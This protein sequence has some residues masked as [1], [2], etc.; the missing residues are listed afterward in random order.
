MKIIGML[1]N[2][3]LNV[4]ITKDEYISNYQDNDNYTTDPPNAAVD[5]AWNYYKNV[6]DEQEKNTIINYESYNLLRK[7]KNIGVFFVL[8]TIANIVTTIILMLK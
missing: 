1:P 8:L 2:G 7:I 3:N 5:S 4:E 6:D